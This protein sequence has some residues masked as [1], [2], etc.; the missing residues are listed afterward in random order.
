M[1]EEDEEKPSEFVLAIRELPQRERL[2]FFQI[3]INGVPAEDVALQM[4]LTPKQVETI[5]EEACRK[6]GLN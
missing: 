2:I 4:D 3:N 5:Y 1:N 6:L